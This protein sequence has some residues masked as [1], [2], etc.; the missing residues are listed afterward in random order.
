MWFGGKS[1][2]PTPHPLRPTVWFFIFPLWTLLLFACWLSLRGGGRSWLLTHYFFSTWVLN[3][4]Q[5]DFFFISQCPQPKLSTQ[6]PP[7][8]SNKSCR[9][10]SRVPWYPCVGYVINVVFLPLYVPLCVWKIVVGPRGL[11]G[12]LAAHCTA[13]KKK[14]NIQ[15]M[16]GLCRLFHTCSAFSPSTLFVIH[17]YRGRQVPLKHHILFRGSSPSEPNEHVEIQWILICCYIG[18]RDKSAR[19]DLLGGNWKERAALLDFPC[20]P[21]ET[22]KKGTM[23][24]ETINF[25]DGNLLL[26]NGWRGA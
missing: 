8:I 16:G 21:S 9:P 6:L 25:G 15:L 14:K 20:I 26:F 1:P 10:G 5:D 4:C 11:D 17:L 24:D 13:S 2:P 23:G 19:E 3:S 7:V 12:R 22:A 18:T